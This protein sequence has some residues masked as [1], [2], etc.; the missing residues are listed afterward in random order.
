M[1][2]IPRGYLAKICTIQVNCPLYVS[3]VMSKSAADVIALKRNDGAV[4]F[5][6]PLA[7]SLGID[8]A[9][10]YSKDSNK[11]RRIVTDPPI[12]SDPTTP[13]YLIEQ[14]AQ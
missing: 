4:V 9:D 14:L 3:G 10:Y 7:C 6:E 1:L 5:G 12:R 13:A 11:G 8:G 2:Q